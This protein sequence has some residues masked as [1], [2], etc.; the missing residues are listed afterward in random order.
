MK[1]LRENWPSMRTL[2]A[3]AKIWMEGEVSANR[4]WMLSI[5]HPFTGQSPQHTWH[6]REKE[7]NSHSRDHQ[8]RR[9]SLYMAMAEERTTLGVK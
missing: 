6:Y 2:S 1:P 9:K 8:Y 7:A 4:G 5:R 3:S